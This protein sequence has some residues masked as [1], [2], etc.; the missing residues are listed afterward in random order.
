MWEAHN[1]TITHAALEACTSIVMRCP[2]ATRPVVA[3][4]GSHHQKNVSPAVNLQTTGF[5]KTLKLFSS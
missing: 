3:D 5:A 1:E 4:R 2:D